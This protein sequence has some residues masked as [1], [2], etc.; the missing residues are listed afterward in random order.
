MHYNR[1]TSYATE[2]AT[3][4]TD[5]PLANNAVALQYSDIWSGMDSVFDT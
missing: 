2:A 4:Y 5:Y 1:D 3:G